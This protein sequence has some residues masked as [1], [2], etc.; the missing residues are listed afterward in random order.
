MHCD[1]LVSVYTPHTQILESLFENTLESK[2]FGQDIELDPSFSNAAQGGLQGCRLGAPS[3]RACW[4]VC[5]TRTL[6]GIK[7]LGCH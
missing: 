1:T 7:P 6:V 2:V 4:G 3:T 5:G